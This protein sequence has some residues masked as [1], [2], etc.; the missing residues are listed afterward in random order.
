MFNSLPALLS[1]DNV[2]LKMENEIAKAFGNIISATN[3]KPIDLSRGVEFE[4]G[5]T[6]LVRKLGHRGTIVAF[7]PM[8]DL[9]VDTKKAKITVEP[10]S[11]RFIRG[12]KK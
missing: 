9:I 4:I 8:A 1:G 5:D 2:E 3:G 7:S 6:V 12:V 10:T 11:V